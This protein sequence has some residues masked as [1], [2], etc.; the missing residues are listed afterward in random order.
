[1]ARRLPQ[2]GA[3][4]EMV[5]EGENRWCQC[6][7]RLVGCAHRRRRLFTVNGPRLLICNLAHCPE[8][9]CPKHGHLAS[10][11]GEA[12]LAMPRW[13]I[14]WDVFC[15]L[16]HRRFARHWSVPQLRAELLDSCAIELSEDAIEDYLQRY[17]C[18]LAARQQDFALLKKEYASTRQ[19]VL[20]IEGLQPEKGHETLYVER[21]LTHQRVWFAK[22]LLS[23]AT[24]KIRPL[25]VQAKDWAERLGWRVRLWMSDKQD[26]LVKTIASV[27]P[28]VPHRYCSNHFLRELAKPVLELGSHAKVPMRRKIRG[29]RAIEREVLKEQAAAHA[30]QDKDQKRLALKGGTRGE[31]DGCRARLL[32]GGSRHPQRPSRRSLASAGAADVG[33][34]G[35]RAPIAAA[36]SAAQKRGRAEALLE[37]LT[38][39]SDKGRNLVAAAQKQVAGYVAT[40][41]KVDALLE[42]ATDRCAKRRQRYGAPERALLK[43][44]DVCG[45]QLGRVMA[46]FQAGLFAGGDRGDWPRE[47]LDLERWFRLPKGHER[48]IHGRCHAGVR[49]VQEGETMMLAWDA[50]RHPPQPFTEE[51]LR[52]YRD[53]EVPDTQNE[54]IHR[55]KVMRAGRTTKKRAALLRELEKRHAASIWH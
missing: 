47:N 45:Q 52:S 55:R 49:I 23:S 43:D 3:G 40:I 41:R 26:A 37:R 13:L 17:Q 54:A 7:R 46:S 33:G 18:M 38:S 31:R 5:L 39:C 48:R 20:S 12:I 15:W 11:K 10:P 27:C 16:G 6:G 35:R 14:G 1:M 34:A 24:S 44:E 42:P 50:H 25:I 8:R 36:S 21:E 29:L 53:A 19:V 28:G 22:P 2:D 30:G 32:C 4:T 9:T 51:E